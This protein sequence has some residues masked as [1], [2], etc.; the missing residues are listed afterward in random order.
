MMICTKSIYRTKEMSWGTELM[1]PGKEP[2][3]N[4][5]VP[6]NNGEADGT[7][8]QKILIF[9]LPISCLWVFV[10]YKLGI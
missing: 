1:L 10:I 2:N 4:D 3:H 8:E 5:T 9:T 6:K 7:N